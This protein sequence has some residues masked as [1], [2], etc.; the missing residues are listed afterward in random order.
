MGAK[1]FKVQMRVLVQLQKALNSRL[2][3]YSLD[4]NKAYS[5]QTGA[6]DQQSRISLCVEWNGEQAKTPEQIL[7][8]A[9]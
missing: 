3:A 9:G 4:T 1:R 7:V 8:P 2:K 5:R 6:I